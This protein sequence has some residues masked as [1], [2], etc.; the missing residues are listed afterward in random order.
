MCQGMVTRM[1]RAQSEAAKAR[2]RRESLEQCPTCVGTGVVVS[3]DVKAKARKGG[4]NS[5]LS[6]LQPGQLSMGERGAK[7]GRPKEPSLKDLV[8]SDRGME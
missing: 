7:G 2:Y 1:A 5:F 3:E 8:D 4:V 6:S